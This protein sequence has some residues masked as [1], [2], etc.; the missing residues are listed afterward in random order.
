[1]DHD[2]YGN[3]LISTLVGYYIFLIICLLIIPLWRIVKYYF[4]GRVPLVCLL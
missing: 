2:T 4:T 3:L 1:M